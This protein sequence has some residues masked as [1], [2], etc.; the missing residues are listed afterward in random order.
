M[1]IGFARKHVGLPDRW[2][3]IHVGCRGFELNL[4]RVHVHIFDEFCHVGV[5]GER[6]EGAGD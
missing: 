2:R 3:Q 6:E 1:T 5:R 4:L